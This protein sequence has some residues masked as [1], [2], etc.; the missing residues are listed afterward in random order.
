MTSLEPTPLAG[1]TQHSAV[2]TE[3]LKK[4]ISKVQ[5]SE[6]LR[7]ACLPKLLCEMAARPSYLLTE[8]EKDLLT[9][10]K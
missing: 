8:R 6:S 5:L 7:D 9:I 2:T 10:I 3:N 4:R 1:V